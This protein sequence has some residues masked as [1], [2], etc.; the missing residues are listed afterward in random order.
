MNYFATAQRFQWCSGKTTIPFAEPWILK[1]AFSTLYVCVKFFFFLWGGT[2]WYAISPLDSGFNWEMATS[3]SHMK[4][5]GLTRVKN[6]S[7]WYWEMY[8]MKAS[9][10]LNVSPDRSAV[11]VQYILHIHFS[12]SAV[13]TSNTLTQYRMTCTYRLPFTWPYKVYCMYSI[14]CS[15]TVLLAVDQQY[16]LH[17]TASILHFA[18]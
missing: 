18:I 16:I 14:Y 4:P 3:Q 5:H 10:T 12:H 9:Q 7:G 8:Y 2:V 17:P 15:Y 13:Y 1:D 11:E 6:V